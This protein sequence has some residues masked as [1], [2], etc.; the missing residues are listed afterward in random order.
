[1]RNV[2][3]APHSLQGRMGVAALLSELDDLGEQKR[4]KYAPGAPS[5][6][7]PAKPDYENTVLEEQNNLKYLSLSLCS[8]DIH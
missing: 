8:E 6:E 3:C 1:M 5:S 7:K 2:L 4:I